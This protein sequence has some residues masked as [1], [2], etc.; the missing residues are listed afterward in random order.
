MIKKIKN[1][2]S[3]MFGWTAKTAQNKLNIVSII[4]VIIF[5]IFLF[6]NVLEWYNYQK[7]L[8]DSPYNK[9]DCND[10]FI[11]S[12]KYNQKTYDLDLLRSIN[13]YKNYQSYEETQEEIKINYSKECE[14]VLSKVNAI[15]W[16]NLTNFLYQIDK[17]SDDIYE[18]NQKISEYENEYEKYKSELDSWIVS[19]NDR[20]SDISSGE[21][22]K[23]YETLK[24]SLN[25]LENSRNKLILDF[26]S[27]NTNYKELKEYIAQN[28]EN[29][30]K[31]Y[32]KEIFWYPVKVALF[33]TLLLLPLFLISLYFYRVFLRKQNRI[34]TILFANLSFI[35]GLFVFVLFFKFLYFIIPKKLFLNFINFLKSLNLWF[36]WNYILTLIW[37]VVFGLIIY[38][39][40]Q[41]S[42][43]LAKI[44]AEQELEKI[45]L[46]KT[47]ISKDRF[48]K[49]NCIDCGE[50]LLANSKFCSHC[51]LSQY[52]KCDSC[53]NE[54]P[55]CF[56]FCNK[57]GKR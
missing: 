42:Q 7:N 31:N 18:N 47:K 38:F 4:L 46:N 54:Y 56:E 5:D 10:F 2:L 21:A 44:R 26:T 16:D 28:I 53:Q 40:Q 19:E 25:D 33:Q 43:K 24:K 48:F 57:C 30:N 12:S 39:S 23:Q 34:L 50:K 1:F 22:R 14:F 13:N 27:W 52:K 9:F 32:D 11:K 37:V 55:K 51:G 15:K 41:S 3:N 36:L 49:W 29:Y 20:L 6:H 45:R 17:I 8:V 35:T